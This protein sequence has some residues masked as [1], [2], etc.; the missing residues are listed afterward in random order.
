MFY[1]ADTMQHKALKL[2]ASKLSAA[3]V[4]E[5]G[6]SDEGLA[7]MSECQDM[8]S[9][10]AKELA[11]GIKDSVEDLSAT[12]KRMALIKEVEIAPKP[13]A[14]SEPQSTAIQVVEPIKIIAESDSVVIQKQKP[15]SSIQYTLFDL[16]AG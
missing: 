15:S 12:F 3:T 16:L 5:G 6:I 13:E 8:T 9:Q 1:Y 10:M 7:A 2:M 4:I 11:A 14:Q